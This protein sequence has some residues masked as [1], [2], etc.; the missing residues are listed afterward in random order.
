M[1]AAPDGFD[2]DGEVEAL[3]GSLYLQQHPEVVETILRHNPN[4]LRNVE[5]PHEPAAGDL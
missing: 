3:E 2:L 4:L 5:V 1:M